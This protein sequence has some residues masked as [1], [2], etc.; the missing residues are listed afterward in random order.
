[1]TTYT[2]GGYM[3][4]SG[5]EGG[6][7]VDSVNGLTGTVTLTTGNIS[8]VT[9]KKY[10]TDAEKTKLSS[11]SGT[12]TG[13]QNSSTVLLSAALPAPLASET[14][15]QGALSTIAPLLDSGGGTSNLVVYYDDFL[16]TGTP[17]GVLPDLVIV[18]PDAGEVSFG[19]TSMLSFNLTSSAGVNSGGVQKTTGNP[20]NTIVSCAF[21]HT[22]NN[23]FMRDTFFGYE[24]LIFFP[25]NET[26]RIAIT[27]TLV[28]GDYTLFADIENADG[29][30]TVALGVVTNTLNNISIEFTETDV[31]FKLNEETPVTLA[32]NH[33]N[34]PG[35]LS[36]GFP[37]LAFSAISTG[38]LASPNR[39]DLDYLKV[40]RT[41]V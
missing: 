21:K 18:E 38:P 30:H 17:F 35:F 12:N 32:K 1:M 4:P 7:A 41:N 22:D 27:G 20:D 24:S 34:M 16:Y 15:V 3:T 11:T 8:E 13:D 29:R 25:S 14:T 6:G 31:I 37:A 19:T 9:N 5:G 36:F 23:E 10:V 2:N 40:E 28:S 26:N 33:V 39:V